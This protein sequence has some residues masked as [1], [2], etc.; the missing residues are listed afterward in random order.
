MIDTR[1]KQLLLC[2]NQRN[3]A[4]AKGLKYSDLANILM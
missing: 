4:L 2:D 1:H 3:E